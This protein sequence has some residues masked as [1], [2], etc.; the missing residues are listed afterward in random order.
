LARN[1]D[2][3]L[4]KLVYNYRKPRIF[5]PINSTIESIDEFVKVPAGTF[6]ECLKIKPVGFAEKSLGK[7]RL[8]KFQYG[9]QRKM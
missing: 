3:L 9:Y 8:R 4:I 2:I 6:K 7:N 1:R 5:V